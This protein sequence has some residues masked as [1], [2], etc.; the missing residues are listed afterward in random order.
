V[1]SEPHA[2]DAARAILRE[3]IATRATPAAVVEVGTVREVLWREA[4]GRLSFVESAAEAT[5]HTIFDLASLTKVMATTALAM[6]AVEDGQLALDEALSRRVSVWH[7]DDRASVTVADLLEHCSGLTSY[8]PF[9]NE[10][11]M[12]GRAEY[13]RAICSLPLEHPPRTQAV[14]SDLGFMLLGFMLERAAGATLDVQFDAI[15]ALV[16]PH[17]LRFLPPS[18]WRPR[19]APTEVCPVRGRLLVGEVHDGNAWALGGVAGHAG[20][21]GTAA[22]VGTFARLVLDTIARDTALARTTTLARFRQPSTVP[23]SSR[24]LGWDTMR[25]TSSCGRLMSPQAMGHTGFTG[26]SLWIDPARDLYV[27][28]LSNRVHAG[29]GQE[30]FR[31]IRPLVHDA[32]VEGLDGANE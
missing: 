1:R 13:E 28:L 17:R 3:A 9:F 2:F 21:F 31:A 32:V 12:R 19:L 7:G 22:A 4:F 16:T 11:S 14:Y 30:A 10:P 26:T 5:E 29:G 20:L 8:M 23:G 27:V 15:S 18:D 25:P 24:A 6:R